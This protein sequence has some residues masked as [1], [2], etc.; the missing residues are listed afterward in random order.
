MAKQK[1]Q[2][3]DPNDLVRVLVHKA[4]SIGGVAHRPFVDGKKVTPT[5]AVIRR[6]RAIAHG[7]D[8]EIID[9]PKAEKDDTE[10]ADEKTGEK[11][12]EKPEQK[13]TLPPR[14]KQVAGGKNKS[15]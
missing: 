1:S 9:E 13:Q 5:E 6:E 11:P 10:M 8:V 2:H 3:G 12:D 7:G 15:A 4:I 14:D